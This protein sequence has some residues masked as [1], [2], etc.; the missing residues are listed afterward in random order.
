MQILDTLLRVVIAFSALLIWSRIIGKKLL[1]LM[2]FFDFVTGVTFGA[3][4]GNIIFN[5]TVSLWTGV[6]ALSSFSILALAADYISLKSLKGRALLEG[7]PTLIIDHGE[8]KVKTL[9]KARLAATDL[10]MLLRKQGIFSLQDVEMAYFETD[11]SISISKKPS[12]KS[13]T[14]Q[15]L[16]IKSPSKNIPVLCIVDGKMMDK[17]LSEIG[18][19]KEWLE[20]VLKV[21]NICLEHVFLAQINKDGQIHFVMK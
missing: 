2:T 19:N 15:D 18:K 1:S 5:H 6:V 11:G 8:L 3:L 21:K 14:C 9:K 17:Q 10:A 16:N 13:P 20:N 4:G 12:E 7:E